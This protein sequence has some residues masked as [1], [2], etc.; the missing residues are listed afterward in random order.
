MKWKII[1]DSGSDIRPDKWESKGVDFELVPLQIH[2]NHQSYTDNQHIDL[3]EFL[4]HMKHQRQAGTTSCPSPQ[5]FFDAFKNTE[6]D[7]ILCFTLS[8]NISGSY[9]SACTA[10]KLYLEEGGQ[11][12]I[13]IIDSHSA[14][15]EIDLMIYQAREWMEAGLS[16]EELTNK[17]KEYC[18][19]TN[20]LFI[21]ES[22]NNLIKNGRIPHILGQ[23]IGFLNIRIIGKR[24]KEGR[25]ELAT[26][27]RGHKKA[28]RALLKEML[29]SGYQGGNIVISHVLN[30]QAAQDFLGLVQEKFPQIQCKILEC[31]ALCTFYAEDQGLI[32]GFER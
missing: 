20:V 31:S 13:Y 26:K 19:K 30:E 4:Q 3:K 21:L 32:V 24:S 5:A 29:A 10:K 18:Q 16:F 27:A 9:N 22:V 14:G 2:F 6:A 17:M 1:T 28:Q 23:V 8:S 25:I 11:K 12:N 15:A 7:A